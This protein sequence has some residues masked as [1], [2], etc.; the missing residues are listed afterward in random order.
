MTKSI[1]QLLDT[2]KSID[3]LYQATSFWDAGVPLI[4]K[5]LQSEGFDQFRRWS[6]SLGFFVPT[7]GAPGN[8]LTA[9]LI[10]ALKEW[11]RH[12]KLNPKQHNFVMNWATGQL[13]AESDFRVIKA[14]V[15]GTSNEFLL[16]F[17]ESDIGN[18]IE[19]MLIDGKSHSRSSLNYL[20]GLACLGKFIDL[21]TINTVLEIG[22]GYGTLGEIFCQLWGQDSKYLN[23]DIPPI[24]NVA[25][26]YLSAL[27]DNFTGISDLVDREHIEFA[28]LSRTN[29]APNWKIPSIEGEVDL[30]VNMISFQEMER[31]VVENYL[32]Q[33]ESLSPKYILLRHIREGKQKRT[34]SNPIGVLEPTTPEIYNDIL[35]GYSLMHRDS[36][37]FGFDTPDH[38]HS[39]VIVYQRMQ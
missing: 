20:M 4:T 16:D 39:D 34:P 24:C 27:S 38:F 29:V 9:D 36:V 33:V 21:K 25:E 12:Q 5:D 31:S 1:H 15:M 3:P 11:S 23:L 14:A 8:S 19:R 18:P 22:G 30:F 26:Y 28:K 10:E 13:T 32:N 37:P 17:S 6:H 2:A 7:Y 35:R